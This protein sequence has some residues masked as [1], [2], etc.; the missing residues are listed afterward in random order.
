MSRH[1]IALHGILSSGA[2]LLRIKPHFLAAGLRFTLVPVGWTGIVGTYFAHRRLARSLA[3]LLKG[4][5]Q[6]APETEFIGLGHSWGGALIQKMLDEGAPFSKALLINPA[7]D[8]DADFPPECAVHVFYTPGDIPTRIGRFLPRHP[9]GAMGAKG[10]KSKG[11]RIRGNV[12]PHDMSDLPED[13]HGHS[14]AL[15]E[16]DAEAMAGRFL[17]ALDMKMPGMVAAKR[18]RRNA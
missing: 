3:A 1:V 15:S 16:E 12:M 8:R 18:L 5:K 9:F 17:L 14:E 2:G 4:W 6:D 10:P 11:V 13:I 7:L